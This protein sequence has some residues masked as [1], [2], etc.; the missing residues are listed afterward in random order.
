MVDRQGETSCGPIYIG[1]WGDAA[2]RLGFPMGLP[3]TTWYGP[4]ELKV[5]FTTFNY[6]YS[7]FSQKKSIII[8]PKKTSVLLLLDRCNAAR[9]GRTMYVRT[10]EIETA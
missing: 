5:I 10:V 3:G 2:A 1:G 9:I 7:P 6:Y 4:F 8:L